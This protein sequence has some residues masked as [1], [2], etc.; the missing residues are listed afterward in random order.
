ML[1]DYQEQ[2]QSSLS[3]S[4]TPYTS[5]YSGS[6][7]T[8]GY[9]WGYSPSTFGYSWGYSPSTFGY[10]WGYSPSTFGY[11]WGYSPSTFGYSWGYSPS[12]FGYS[13]YTPYSSFGYSG[14]T[15]YSWGYSGSSFGY[16]YYTPYSSYYSWYGRR[17]EGNDAADEHGNGA[18]KEEPTRGDRRDLWSSYYSSYWSYTPYSSYWSYTPYSSWSYT[19]YSSYWSYTPYS[20]W[21]YSPYSSWGYSWGYSPYSSSFGYSWGYSPYSWGYSPYS[22]SFGYSWGYSPYSSWGYSPYYTPYS[23]AYGYSSWGY[24]GYTPYQWTWSYYGY[25]DPS[26]PTMETSS[27]EDLVEAYCTD[28]EEEESTA[29]EYTCAS[30]PFDGV[31]DQELK[32]TK[33]RIAMCEQDGRT[34]CPGNYATDPKDETQE[35]RVTGGAEYWRYCEDA[36]DDENAYASGGTVQASDVD[37]VGVLYVT[38]ES[39]PAMIDTSEQYHGFTRYPAW[40]SVANYYYYVYTMC[41]Q[42]GQPTRNSDG[43]I[44]YIAPSSIGDYESAARGYDS[45]ANVRL[46]VKAA[47]EDGATDD[48]TAYLSTALATVRRVRTMPRKQ[49]TGKVTPQAISTSAGSTGIS[50]SQAYDNLAAYMGLDNWDTIYEALVA[51]DSSLEEEAFSYAALAGS[52]SSS[53]SSSSSGS[54]SSS[55]YG[56]SSWGYS[57]YSSFGYS[58][59]YSPY[60]SFGY[61]WGY[62]PYSWGYS[63]GY[64]PYSWGYSWGY[65]PYSSSF[66]YSWGYSPYSSW[67]YSGYTPYSSF[68]YSGYTPYS[69]GYSGYTPYSSFGYSG[70]T[71]YSWGYSG[72]TPYSSFGYGY[73]T[74]YSSYY[75]YYG[76][77][78]SDNSTSAPEDMSDNSMSDN[79]TSAPEMAG[80]DIAPS[81][82][83]E[84]SLEFNEAA[85][86]Q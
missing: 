19:P 32:C 60:S 77:R 73:Y 50:L 38:L 31:Y 6:S 44:P 20:S 80:V 8:F 30:R 48:P 11:S 57:P 58:W 71:P 82:P 67:G 45:Y 23:S 34:K 86:P 25:S 79:S 13:G 37:G 39:T 16:G 53:S 3:G 62:S 69:W 4:S 55:Y 66:G 14:Y 81:A 59:G 43:S 33:E 24:S 64:S 52:G 15:P 78:L 35:C 61:S 68:G 5:T 1:E 10:S 51:E 75:G 22:S 56:S 42:N 40:V 49:Y 74:P 36:A 28:E 63:W 54:S 85:C 18:E 27:L 21:G 29:F 12:T 84:V 47:Y 41:K 83:P 72:Y 9:S 2:Y 26:L 70:Y 65:S 17:L 7:S 76:R 46:F